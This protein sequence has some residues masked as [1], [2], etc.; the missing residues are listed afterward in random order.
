MFWA[1]GRTQDQ[2]LVPYF[3]WRLGAD[4]ATALKFPFRH[5]NLS[6]DVEALP[7]RYLADSATRLH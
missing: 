3:L 2:F 6:F 4:S 5:A 1:L 7:M